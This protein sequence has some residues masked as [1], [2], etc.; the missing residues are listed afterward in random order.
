MSILVAIGT[1]YDYLISINVNI[2][3]CMGLIKI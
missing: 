3:G 1:Y 2:G